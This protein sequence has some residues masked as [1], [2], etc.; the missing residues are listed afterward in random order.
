MSKKTPVQTIKEL[1]QYLPEKD[2]KFANKFIDK[3]D[4]ESLSDLVKSDIYKIERDINS[5]PEEFEDERLVKQKVLSQLENLKSEVDSYL[6]LL[7]Y[8][9]DELYNNDDYDYI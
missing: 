9:E 1:V 7:G 5:I 8:T 2:I 3:R 6:M 4:F